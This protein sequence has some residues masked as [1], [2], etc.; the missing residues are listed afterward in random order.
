MS[1]QNKKIQA[2]NSRRLTKL[3]NK[4]NTCYIPFQLNTISQK[5]SKSQTTTPTPSG[6][7][8]ENIRLNSG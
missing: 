8:S 3:N 2:N 4:P 7:K 6:Q 5:V 1:F